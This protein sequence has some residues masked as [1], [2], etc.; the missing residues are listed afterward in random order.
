MTDFINYLKCVGMVI[1]VLALVLVGAAVLIFITVNLN[2]MILLVFVVVGAILG[3]A[4]GIYRD[5]YP[6]WRD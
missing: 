6:D 5:T 4:Y 1:A 3:I 2:P